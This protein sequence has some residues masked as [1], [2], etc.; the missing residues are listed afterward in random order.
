VDITGRE[1]MAFKIVKPTTQ[2]PISNL[3]AG[4]YFVKVSDAAGRVGVGKFVKE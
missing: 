2:I 3:R 1:L 4:L